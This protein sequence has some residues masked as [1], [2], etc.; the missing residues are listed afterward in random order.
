MTCAGGQEKVAELQDSLEEAEVWVSPGC[1]RWWKEDVGLGR[2]AVSSQELPV[3]PAACGHGLSTWPSWRRRRAEGRQRLAGS[4]GAPRRGGE[5]CWDGRG[6]VGDSQVCW[7]HSG[8]PGIFRCAGDPGPQRDASASHAI[9]SRRSL[10]NHRDKTP[11]ERD[12]AQKLS[13]GDVEE[14]FPH[15]GTGKRLQAVLS[16]PFSPS[17]GSHPVSTP[18]FPVPTG[19]TGN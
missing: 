5:E 4:L 9:G 2:S 19:I 11:L 17:P 7:G 6:C 12:R 18:G 10:R 3:A 1:L 15:P 16:P 14:P 8:V 13:W